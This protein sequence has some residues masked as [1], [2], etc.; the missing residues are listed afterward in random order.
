MAPETFE[1]MLTGGHPN[2]L[3]RTLDVVEIVLADRDRLEELFRCYRSDDEVVRLRT[4]NALKRVDAEKHMWLIPFID[5]LISE[6][7]ALDQASAQWTLAQLF[8]KLKED[9]TVDQLSSSLKIMKRNLAESD[10]WIVLTQ[11]M[12]TLSVWATEDVALKKWLRPHL[13]RLAED[14]RKSVKSKATKMLKKLSG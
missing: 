8:G 1:Q 11:T 2:S 9:M 6:T 5:R 13:E 14:A 4:S 7:G 12:E 3:G 10:D